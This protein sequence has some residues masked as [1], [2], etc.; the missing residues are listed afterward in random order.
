MS[1]RSAARELID[2]VTYLPRQRPVKLAH[3]SRLVFV[4]KGNIC[5]SAYAE[6]YATCLGMEAGSFGVQTHSGLPADASAIAAAADR[7][8]DLS[9]HRTS[10]MAD[11][12]LRAGDVLLAM[13]PWHAKLLHSHVREDG[14]QV[15]LLGGFA[16]PRTSIIR[17]PYGKPPEIFDDCFVR[18][19]HCVQRIR[20]ATTAG[21]G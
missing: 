11:F 9:L 7:G 5:R 1:V 4:C 16:M 6:A 3:A 21:A 8:V 12:S 20:S 17:D 14:V 19:E 15:A 18:I 10:A 2:Y 13:E